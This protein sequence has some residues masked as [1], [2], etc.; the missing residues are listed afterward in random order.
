MV[1]MKNSNCSIHQNNCCRTSYENDEYQHIL[2]I[3]SEKNEKSCHK[4]TGFSSH[5][6]GCQTG[7]APGIASFDTQAAMVIIATRPFL[8]S[9]SLSFL[10]SSLSKPP[11][12]L[13]KPSGS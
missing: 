6:H 3:I 8:I 1:C 2:F 4:V 7:S 10:I 9:M 11:S 13:V 5:T 12:L